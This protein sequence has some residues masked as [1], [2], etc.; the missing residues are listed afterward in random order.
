MKLNLDR[1]CAIF[2]DY[3]C[4]FL[5][6]FLGFELLFSFEFENYH[7]AIVALISLVAYY[8]VFGALFRHRLTPGEK[9]FGVRT[10]DKQYHRIKRLIDDNSP[11]HNPADLPTSDKAALTFYVMLTLGVIA[12][13]A[14]LG[15]SYLVF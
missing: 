3:I 5:F 15:V 9:L 8:L 4:L 2:L 1:V 11:V 7:L 10:R 6:V 13:L 14:W 12:G